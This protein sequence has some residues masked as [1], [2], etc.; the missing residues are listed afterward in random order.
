MPPVADLFH[1]LERI[2]EEQ[3]AG[4]RE[5]LS[6]MGA[7]EEALVTGQPDR[8]RPL[9]RLQEAAASR[10][11]CA[12]ERRQAASAKLAGALGLP[13]DAALR[14]IARSLPASDAQRALALLGDMT[15]TMGD[16]ASS[17]RRNEALVRH[18]VAST[19]HAIAVLTEAQLRADG[20]YVPPGRP[21]RATQGV[22]DC[23]V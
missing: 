1:Q 10:L 12:E 2:L 20:R 19:R 7:Q 5:L 22:V 11:E 15:R 8:I 6:L 18:A 16:L 21:R 9:V 23:Q 3:L 14:E 4:L 13:P 17:S